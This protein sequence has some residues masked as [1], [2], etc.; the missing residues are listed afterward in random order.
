MF[1][2]RFA[3]GVVLTLLLLGTTAHADGGRLSGI[4]ENDS[5]AA[6]SDRHYTQGLRLTYLTPQ[7]KDGWDEPYGWMSKLLPF[8]EGTDRKRKIAWSLEQSIFTPRETHI[9]NPDTADR[10]YAGWLN[11]GASFLQARQLSTHVHTLENFEIQLGVVGPAA[12]G[13]QAQNDWHQIIGAPKA[14][15]WAH[16]L[17]NEPA[18]TLTY[19]RKWRIEQPLMEGLSVDIIP[20]VGATV[21]NVLTYGAVGATV[22]IGR[23]LQV[24]YG[25]ARIRP[26]LSGTDWFACDEKCDGDFGWYVFIG[27]EGRLVARNIFL[28]GSSFTSSPSVDKKNAV[29]DI[30]GGVSL[31]WSDWVKL[32]VSLT[33]RTKEFV[34]QTKQDKFAVVA[35]SFG[36]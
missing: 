6:N 4:E 5:I 12:L 15:G 1:H 34:G 24:D 3:T 11:I 13:R 19:E 29:A 23:N 18:L 22:R 2:K 9:A 36:L 7:L 8:S 35:L 26:A 10:P 21:G 32:D 14:L 25:Q 30:S 17:P 20:E 33:R 28:D 31:F 16:Q 27:T